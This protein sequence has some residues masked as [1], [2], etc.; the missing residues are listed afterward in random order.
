M[1][2]S[3]YLSAVVVQDLLERTLD[4]IHKMQDQHR[5]NPRELDRLARQQRDIEKNLSRVMH[6]LA[7]ASKV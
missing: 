5:N 1:A 3:I 4:D 7:D 2:C 6:Q